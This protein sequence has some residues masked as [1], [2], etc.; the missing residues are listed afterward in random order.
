MLAA[1]A[2]KGRTQATGLVTLFFALGLLIPP[3]SIL[4]LALVT[5]IGLR[6]GARPGLEVAI[7]ASLIVG[8]SSLV[9]LGSATAGFAMAILW[10]PML[11]LALMLRYSGSLAMTLEFALL[12]ALLIPV[13]GGLLV[14]NEADAWQKLLQPLEQQLQSSGALSAEES[15]SFVE[16]LGRWLPALLATGFFLQQALA[17]FLARSWQAKLFN[18]GG[19]Q[20][21]FHQLRV[22][23]WL[24]WGATAL[25]LGIWLLD[26]SQWSLGRSLIALLGVIF[27]LQG[28]AVLHALLAKA[29]SG[30]FWLIGIY[31]LLLLALPYMGMMLAVTGYLD[32]WRDFRRMNENPT[33]PDA[34]S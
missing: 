11:L 13:L 34:G 20:Q 28:L 9:L 27:L 19:F 16:G 33:S 8:I 14:G 18:P 15:R 2:L 1:Y 22:S 24:T 26:A 17:L 4:A 7:A 23:K 6:L 29:S 31:A 12:L 25:L 21:E 32:A 10:I 5:L 3:L 30:Q